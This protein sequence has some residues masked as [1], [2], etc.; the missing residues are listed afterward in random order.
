[1]NGDQDICHV[2]GMPANPVVESVEYHKMFF[3]FCSEQ[4]RETFLEN[5]GLYA[6]K[7]AAER[8]EILKRR[9]LHLAEPPDEEIATLLTSYLKELMGVKEVEVEGD[10]LHVSYDLLQV[11]EA[12]IEEA[13][14]EAGLQLDDSWRERLRRAWVHDTE[15]IE[16]KNLTAKPGACCNKPPP[17]SSK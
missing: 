1:M 15:E 3:H 13:L 4:C 16:L 6:S 7:P 9:T 5:P 11:T 2:C 14:T 12:Q 8:Q 17:G 10:R